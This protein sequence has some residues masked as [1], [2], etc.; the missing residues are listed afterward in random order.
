[1]GSI[2]TKRCHIYFLVCLGAKET[3]SKRCDQKV[4]MEEL[5][6]RLRV[7]QQEKEK[8]DR[9]KLERKIKNAWQTSKLDE[10]FA[11]LSPEEAEVVKDL[12]SGAAVGSHISHVWEVDDGTQPFCGRIRQI[13][14]KATRTAPILYSVDYWEAEEGEETAEDWVVKS[15][16]LAADLINGD[17]VLQD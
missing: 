13:K 15:T 8:K 14:K 6:R 16:E 7:K 1:M 4:L 17:L 11:D 10:E 9:R 2:S 12:L 3:L 5:F